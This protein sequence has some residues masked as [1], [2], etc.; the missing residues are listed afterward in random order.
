MSV[1][2]S[3]AA[4]GTPTERRTWASPCTSKS[5]TGCSTYW[6]SKCSRPRIHLIAAGT[7][8]IMFASIRIL[9]SVPTSSRIAAM[10]VVI[11]AEVAPHLQLQLRVAGVHERR[12]L[13]RV[14]LRLVDEEVAD[15][16]RLPPAEAAEQLGDRDVERLALE[17]EQR[18]LDPGDRVG[19]DPAPVARELLHP[20]HEPL[21]AERILADEELR[22]LRVDDRP[23]RR[24]R[25]PGSLADADDSL[26]RVDLDEQ[27]G[28]G[29]ARPARPDERL[30]HRRAHGNRID[31]GDLHRRLATL[32]PASQDCQPS[33]DCRQFV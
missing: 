12:R 4:I 22:Q 6:R 32:G 5:G 3:S 2:P 16:G 27:A 18:D 15:D 9:T 1:Q 8:Q 28:G 20:V 31:A 14:R 29:L 24:Q 11:L 13:A 33:V 30:P 17:V 7:L 25:R 10:R 21:R 19:A 23:D 26:V